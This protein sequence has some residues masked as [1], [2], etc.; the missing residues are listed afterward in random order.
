MVAK[1]ARY[2]WNHQKIGISFFWTFAPKNIAEE[3]QLNDDIYGSVE[4]Q[5]AVILIVSKQLEIRESLL[6]QQ[7]KSLPVDIFTGP[8][9]SAS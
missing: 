8:D 4:E 9:T 3:Q 7:E 6:E 5:M 1:A 2:M